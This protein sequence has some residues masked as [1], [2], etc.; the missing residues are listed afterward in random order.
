MFNKNEVVQELERKYGER[1][2]AITE[3][4]R[5]VDSDIDKISLIRRLQTSGDQRGIIIENIHELTKP[6]ISNN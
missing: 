3:E 1:Y 5:V 4:I 6:R 2:L